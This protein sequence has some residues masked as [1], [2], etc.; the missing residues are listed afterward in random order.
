MKV[1]TCLPQAF[2]VGNAA[3][4]FW[5]VE[6]IPAAVVLSRA[7]DGTFLVAAGTSPFDRYIVENQIVFSYLATVFFNF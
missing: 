7:V 2:W 4:Q 5:E 1:T 6:V 3:Q